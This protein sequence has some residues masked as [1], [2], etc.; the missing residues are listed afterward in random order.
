MLADMHKVCSLTEKDVDHAC[1]CILVLKILVPY[2]WAEFVTI[3]MQFL[4]RDMQC[5]AGIPST[6][7]GV[8]IETKTAW[9]I[10]LC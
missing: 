10:G 6:F 5:S 1:G 7:V 8:H 9:S 4:I 2:Q 3:V